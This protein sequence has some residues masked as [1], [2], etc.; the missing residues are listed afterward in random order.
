MLAPLAPA[1]APWV[2]MHPFLQALLVFH[3]AK[4]FKLIVET[5]GNDLY[6][7][8]QG[9][10]VLVDTFTHFSVIILALGITEIVQAAAR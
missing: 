7:L 5:Q 6:H 10:R 9:T 3:S 1:A 8:M 4:H 2:I